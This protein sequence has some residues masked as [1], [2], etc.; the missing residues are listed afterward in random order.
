MDFVSREELLGLTDVPWETVTIEALKKVAVV[1]GMTGKER[2]SFEASLVTGRGKKSKVNTDN[3]RAKLAARCL[4]DKPPSQG[5]KRLFTDAEA[6]RLGDIRVDVLS[7]I[8][9]SAQKLSGVSDEDID[10]LGKLSSESG[11]GAS[12]SSA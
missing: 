11:P 6:D 3:V 9:A 1:V 4:Y 7:P 10:E 2:D 5:G 8:F 12:S